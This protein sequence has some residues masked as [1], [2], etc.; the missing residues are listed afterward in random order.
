MPTYAQH[1]VGSVHRSRPI[2]YEKLVGP[3]IAWFKLRDEIY[4]KK[5]ENMHKGQEKNTSTST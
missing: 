4:S 5:Q 2:N 1:P 3:L